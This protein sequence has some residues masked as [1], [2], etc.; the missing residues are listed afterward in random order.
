MWINTAMLKIR[1]YLLLSFL[2]NSTDRKRCVATDIEPFKNVSM[3]ITP[4]TTFCMPK[5]DTPN[6]SRILRDV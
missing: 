5:S 1:L 3:V 2:P 6:A 4:P